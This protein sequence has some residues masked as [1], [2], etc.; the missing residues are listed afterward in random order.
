MERN[1]FPHQGKYFVSQYLLAKWGFL[2]GCVTKS[3]E[4]TFVQGRAHHDQRRK[5]I[6]SNFVELQVRA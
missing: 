5:G 6:Y 4:M 1:F 3:P 2:Q